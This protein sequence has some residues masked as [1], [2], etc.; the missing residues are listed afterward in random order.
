LILS[1]SD[2]SLLM[3]AGKARVADIRAVK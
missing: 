2:L 3:A 1:G